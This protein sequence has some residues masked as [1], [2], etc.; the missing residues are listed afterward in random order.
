MA[1]CAVCS[2]TEQAYTAPWTVK[3]NQ[4]LVLDSELVMVGGW[5][6]DLQQI[7]VLPPPLTRPPSSN[8]LV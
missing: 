2:K 1:I 7:R 8:S 5:T 4:P 6:T 3:I